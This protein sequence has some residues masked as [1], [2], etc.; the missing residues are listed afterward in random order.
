[1]TKCGKRA[2]DLG[3]SAVGLLASAPVLAIASIAIR[4]DSRGPVIFRQRRI[5]RDGTPFEI[6]K[7]RTMTDRAQETGPGVVADDPRITRVGRF[8]RDTSIDE[9]PQLFNVLKND[10]SMV[11]PRPTLGYQ[12]EQYTER[13][14]R[15]LE[16]LPGIIGWAQVNGRNQLS[17]AERI[18]LDIWYVDNWS[19][20]LDL[21]ILALTLRRVLGREGTY[22][23][24]GGT[25]LFEQGAS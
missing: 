6:L 3:L 21:R 23:A 14:R 19:M 1:M 17:W 22:S 10:M 4:F 20:K 24:T 15:R 9:L 2:I 18:E 25:M 8:L 5:G 7:L 11:G 12:V 13:Q 16:V